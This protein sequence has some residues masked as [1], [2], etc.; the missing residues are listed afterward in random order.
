VAMAESEEDIR[1]LSQQRA[2]EKEIGISKLADCRNT[3]KQLYVNAE[4]AKLHSATK[5]VLKSI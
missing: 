1:E 2:D 5:L 4:K 3:V